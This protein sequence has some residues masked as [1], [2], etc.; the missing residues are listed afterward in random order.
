MYNKSHFNVT[1]DLPC[2]Q[3]TVSLLF[4]ILSI[5]C[6]TA[7]PSILYHLHDKC[8]T[9]TQQPIKLFGMKSAK[10]K[11]YYNFENAKPPEVERFLPLKHNI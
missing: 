11:M 4:I 5:L 7:F 9:P 2:L 8:S 1:L 10:E 6:I 3:G